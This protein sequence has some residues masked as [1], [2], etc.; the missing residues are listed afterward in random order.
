L[1]RQCELLPL[2]EENVSGITV[3]EFR[4]RYCPTKKLDCNQEGLNTFASSLG[5][6]RGIEAGELRRLVLGNRR[7]KLFATKRFRES[8]A[9]VGIV[10]I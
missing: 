3:H 7:S 6:S 1:P 10:M 2:H 5:I 9:G 8:V 4:S